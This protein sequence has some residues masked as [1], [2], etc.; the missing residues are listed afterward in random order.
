MNHKSAM[1]WKAAKLTAFNFY[2]RRLG[3]GWSFTAVAGGRS[4]V[5]SDVLRMNHFTLR[6]AGA[7]A[8][9]HG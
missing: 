2:E 9:P 3:L 8:I 4:I 5:S 7:E 1:P 6:L